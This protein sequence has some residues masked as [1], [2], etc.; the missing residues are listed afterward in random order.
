MSLFSEENGHGHW[1]SVPSTRGRVESAAFELL[2]Q[3]CVG[4]VKGQK[5]VASAPECND[6][7]QRALEVLSGLSSL[8]ASAINGIGKE[9]KDRDTESDA[10]NNGKAL[11]DGGAD[12][13]DANDAVPDLEEENIKEKGEV[14]EVVVATLN[15][16]ED[17]E[18]VIAAYVFLSA[19]VPVPRI[20]NE[21]LKHDSF[22]RTSTTLVMEAKFPELQFEAVTVIAKLAPY[23]TR[24]DTLPPDRVGDLLQTVLSLEP[25]FK[26]GSPS[27]LTRNSLHINAV[28][29]IQFVYDSL[30]P[31]KQ[32]SLMNDV[33][34]RYAK[35]V[36]SYTVTRAVNKSNDRVNGGEL[37][38]HL[39]T[40]MLLGKGKDSVEEC[41][42]PQL[43]T[44]LVNTIQ[45]RYDPKTTISEDEISYWD[46]SVTQCLQ[47]LSLVV[48][49]DNENLAQGGI[50]LQELKNSVLMVARA[51]KA[52]RKAIDFPS[53]LELI[54]KNGEA[55]AKMAALRIIN[56]MLA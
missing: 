44:S 27:R 19:L 20:R 38:Y 24:R 15:E 56:C 36:K 40:L 33:A 21:L 8:P 43:L 22:I 14:E 41:F 50:K 49:R 30:Q 31:G 52:P 25:N 51:G 23:A 55:A 46:A 42:N 5:A 53:A 6:C 48:W 10:D 34:A 29:G 4:S 32:T 47:I 13:D 12:D 16:V 7:F 3:L 37:A 2:A 26:E 18:L 28:A 11:E 45:W 54:S 35:L 1:R 39:T 9:T 17:T